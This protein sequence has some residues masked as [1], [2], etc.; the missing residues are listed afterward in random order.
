[1]LI[2]EIQIVNE[3]SHLYFFLSNLEIL[4][5]DDICVDQLIDI[6]GLELD[7]P[8]VPVKYYIGFLPVLE[9]CKQ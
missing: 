3:S 9:C 8:E 2:L 4:E 5:I 6:M 1:M 7:F